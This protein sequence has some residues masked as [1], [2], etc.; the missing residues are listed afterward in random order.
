M[1]GKIYIENYGCA[2]NV[3]DGEYIKQSFIS[4]GWTV[5]NEAKNADIIIVNTCSVREETERNMISRIRALRTI[6]HDNQKFVITGCLAKTSPSIISLTSP[7]AIIIGPSNIDQIVN[8]VEN[9]SSKILIGNSTRS[10]EIIPEYKGGVT[11]I[12]PIESGCTWSCTFCVTKFARGNVFSYRPGSLFNAMKRA[13]EN[14]A[15]E[16]YLTGQDTAAYGVEHGFRLP[17]LLKTLLQINGVYRVRV[18]MF[19]PMTAR[20]ILKDLLNVYRLDQRVYKFIHMPVQSG[21]DNV[22]QLMKRY[23]TVSEYEN[24]IKLIR[25]YVPDMFIATDIIV[26]FPGETEEAF[27]NTVKLVEKLKFDKVHIAK[28]S[29]RPHTEAAIM[30][31]LSDNIKKRRTSYLTEIVNKISLERNMKFIGKDLRALIIGKGD[32]G[33][34]EA[35]ADDYRV[36][37]LDDNNEH[38]IGDFILVHIT[39]A[40]PHYLKGQLIDVIDKYP[41]TSSIPASQLTYEDGMV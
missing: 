25:E 33:G 36:I 8:I 20:S 4:K 35:R 27:E 32:K 38:L 21:D 24:M 41:Y 39:E 16:I 18:G 1:A 10:S 23:Y 3:A 40:Y 15:R 12:L 14:G 29:I 13:I 2:F 34:L 17:E 22:L 31:Q 28:Y 37:I 5:T 19:N 6:L 7:E 30:K 26:G 9:N 11:Y